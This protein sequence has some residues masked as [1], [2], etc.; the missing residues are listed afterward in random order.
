MGDRSELEALRRLSELET[1]AAA[2][3]VA[4]PS[5][6][7]PKDS[8]EGMSGAERF[9]KA[10]TNRTNTNAMKL[11]KIFD[12]IGRGALDLVGVDMED[13][14]SSLP[15]STEAIRGQEEE[16]A[17]LRQTG[18]GM[19]GELAADAVM[20]APLGVVGRGMEA[21][22]GSSR[23][24]AV[25]G[26]IMGSRPAQAAVE[27]GLAGALNAD[28]E[29][30]GKGAF[31]GATA[32]AVF[33]RGGR[34]LGRTMQGLV[35]RSPEA[36]QLDQLADLHQTQIRLPLAQA[37]SDEGVVSPLMKFVYGRVLPSLP[38]AE[39]AMARQGQRAGSQFRELAMKEASPGGLGSQQAGYAAGL[40][41]TTGKQVGAGGDVRMSMKNIQDA[42]QREYATT[43][44]SYAFNQP[45]TADFAA[46]LQQRFPNIDDS[47]LNG[48]TRTFDSLSNQY[49]K[50]GVLDGDNLVRMKSQLAELGR[51]AGD[52][53]AGQ[54]F[55][56]AQEFLDDVVR[57]EL[58]QGN[59]PQNLLD[60][61]RYDDL[62]EPWKNFQ[63]VQRAAA[64]SKDP[65]GQFTPQ[66]LSRVVKSMGS[67]RDLAR[68]SAPMQELAA[69]GERTVGQSVP[70]PTFLERAATMSALGG[71]GILTGP[72][73]AAALY[74]IGRTAASPAIQDALMGTTRAQKALT[75]ALR[76]R[77]LTKRLVGADVRNTL[78]GEVAEDEPQQ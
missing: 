30:R 72:G 57:S 50:N 59:N 9:G 70:N 12:D 27:G 24:P 36:R 46:R 47:T 64:R 52:D 10:M 68:G 49:S 32:G 74:G 43:I 41:L 15:W 45:Q 37:A 17:P 53:R 29:A 16:I 23:V 55:Y 56:Q 73:G 76:K 71:M 13:T 25:A 38:G 20:T 1:R 48:V 69:L 8:V 22:A 28:P 6:T 75:E 61:Q 42:F 78:A 14:P 3:K 39:S 33:E 2:R 18:S 26:R 66:E 44:K 19:A 34:L 5:V 63:R 67:D 4:D 62:A 35:L 54:S 11:T 65:E 60:L 31:Q 21:V 40:P 7:A 77:P 51:Q 58:R